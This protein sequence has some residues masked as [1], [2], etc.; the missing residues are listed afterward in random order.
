MSQL[1]RGFLSG[2]YLQEFKFSNPL[3]SVVPVN[4]K[5]YVFG[6][7]NIT[8]SASSNTV[9]ASLDDPFFIDSALIGN[10]S[11]EN[12]EISANNMNGDIHITPSGFG[13]LE[14]DYVNPNSAA[15]LDQNS[16]ISFTQSLT[17][18]QIA[19][20]VTGGTPIASTI[21]AGDGISI[22]NSAGSITISIASGSESQNNGIV[23]QLNN[24]TGTENR[25]FDILPN[26][27]FI[28]NSTV[29][30]PVAYNELNIGGYCPEVPIIYS[31]P[32][33]DS[34]VIGDMAWFVNRN[35]GNYK[36]NLPTGSAEN[37]YCIGFGYSPSFAGGNNIGPT[38]YGSYFQPSFSGVV[39][40]LYL[41]SGASVSGSPKGNLYFGSTSIINLG[42][43][44][45]K[46]ANAT[47]NNTATK[48][49]SY[50][51]GIFIWDFIGKS[52]VLSGSS[53][54]I[55]YCVL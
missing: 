49:N 54:Q 43:V 52:Y 35:K 15:V 38:I 2:S 25:M 27:G 48:Y 30:T 18:G 26:N 53:A 31:I 5:I 6:G 23:W 39:G 28:S 12:D 42:P 14:F 36:V 11:I 20:G 24:Y 22:T 1:A 50:Y 4:N 33:P 40:P 16:S 32:D 7:S 51:N 8:T 21:T 44:K 47:M 19:I 34:W 46:I 13:K 41:M 17:D 9:A 37:K 3:Q 45:I 55:R 29:A 10:I